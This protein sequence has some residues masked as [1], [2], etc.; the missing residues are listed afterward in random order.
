MKQLILAKNIV[1]V[2]QD[3]EILT[4]HA[5]EI[6]DGILVDIVSSETVDSE[7]Y[8]GEILDFSDRT[9]IPGFVQ[10][11]V[12]LC[13]SLFRGLAED[14]E[15]LDWLTKKIFPYE[16]GHNR[17]SLKISV[18]IGLNEL[19]KS[20]TTTILDMGTI[21]FQEVIFEE[22]K[23]SEIRAIAGK[24]MLD[25]ND[26]YPEFVESTDD[27][28]KSTNDLAR[29]F[30]NS[31]KGKLKY[32]FAP[33]FVLSCSEKLLTETREMMSDFIGS[34]YHTHS[35]E[36]KSE[37]EAVL[38]MHQMRNI[39]YFDSINVLNDHTVLAHGIHVDDNEIEILK[40]SSTRISHCPSS[41]LKLGSGIADIPRYLKEGIQ[42]SL[43]ADGA[44]CNNSLSQF[45]EM[46][47][48]SLIQKP[49]HGPTS[50][51]AQTVFRMATIEGAR[52]LHL[53]EEIGSIEIGKKADLV[54]LNLENSNLPVADN[55]IY[56]SIIYSAGSKNVSEV[57]ING[58]FVVSEGKSKIYD[59]QQLY[60]EGNKQLMQ[61]LSRVRVN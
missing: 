27:S 51:D 45:T 43:G 33:R 24:C 5:V 48:A 14:M 41:N 26:L 31:N 2:N 17:D 23:R 38:N 12:H 13:Q 6:E 9:L 29:E 22:L 61:L 46:R 18:Q 57:M 30:H 19:L 59:D 53:E 58:E 44:P 39:E 52:A 8:D 11:H 32:G 49:I 36:N 37:L 10:T 54:F 42:V 25:M 4:N 7:K 34:I 47:L 40:K 60:F 16:N 21:N 50:M 20:G 15:L 28:L 55:N 35:S 3:N 1:T 56:A